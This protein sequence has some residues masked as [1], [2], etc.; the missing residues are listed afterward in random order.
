MSILIGIVAGESIAG[1]S[2]V[3]VSVLTDPVLQARRPT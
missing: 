2:P 3:P 1:K